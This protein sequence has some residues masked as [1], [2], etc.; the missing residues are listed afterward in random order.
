MTWQYLISNG[1]AIVCLLIALR[2]MFYQRGK[3]HRPWVSLVA[4]IIILA[5]AYI[6]FRIFYHQ[7]EQVD[8]SEF[9]LNV[10]ILI[11]VWRAKGNIVKAIGEPKA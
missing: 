9:L 3:N 11:A 5:S 2:L 7:Y 8:F 4:Y 1:N 6:A 10:S